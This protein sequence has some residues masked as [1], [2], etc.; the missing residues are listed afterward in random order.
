M[1][2]RGGRPRRAEVEPAPPP[3]RITGRMA[4]DAQLLAR[5]P[6]DASGDALRALYRTY[7]GELFGFALNALEDRGAA[8][9][10]VQE[11]FTRAWRSAERYDPARASVRTWLDQIAR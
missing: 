8:E 1:R 10:A 9:E 6:S 7:A 3:A 2:T 11:V 5:L 4:S